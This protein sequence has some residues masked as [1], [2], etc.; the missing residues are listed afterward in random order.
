[1]PAPAR[2]ERRLAGRS[3]ESITTDAMAQR[4]TTPTPAEAGP[5]RRQ[6]GGRVTADDGDGSVLPELTSRDGPAGQTPSFSQW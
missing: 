4:S 5:G 3:T 1:A 2:R 6:K